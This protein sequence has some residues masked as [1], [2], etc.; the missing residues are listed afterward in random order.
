MPASQFPKAYAK[1]EKYLQ[2]FADRSRGEMT[3]SDL[4]SQIMREEKQCW[5]AWDGRAR[6]CALT[7]VNNGRKKSVD[8]THCAGEGR[9]DWQ[10][11]MT[12]T[13]TWWARDI[14]AE[15]LDVFCRP[16]HSK[17]LKSAGFRETHRLME[18]SLV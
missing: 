1:L 3:I 8:W 18:M 17:F 11:E 4:V 15:R 16:G 12:N 5:M 9:E 2:S 10:Q 13:I 6:A 7:S 14:G